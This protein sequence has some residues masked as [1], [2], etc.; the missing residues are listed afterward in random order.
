QPLLVNPTGN[1]GLATGGMGDVLSGIV[2][3]L[4][5]QKLA[6]ADALAAGAY[7]H[8]LAGDLCAAEIGPVGFTPSDVIERLPRARAAIL[9]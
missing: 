7:W 2:G 3:T 1:S 6:P 9:A 8:G 4:L 5:A